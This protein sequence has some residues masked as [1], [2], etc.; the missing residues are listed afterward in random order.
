MNPAPQLSLACGA[1]PNTPHD[2]F[3]AGTIEAGFPLIGFEVTRDDWTSQTTRE[4]KSRLN[5]SPIEVLD[6]EVFF[7]NPGEENTR[8]LKALDI[9][10]ELGAKFAL[11]VSVDPDQSRNITRFAELCDAAAERDMVIALEFMKFMAVGSLES[12]VE[13]LS[14]VDHHASALLLD[15]LHFFRCGYGK[16]QLGAIDPTWLQYAQ[17]CDGLAEPECDDMDGLVQDA[18]F[19]RKQLGEGQLPVHDFLGGLPEGI[20]LSIEMRSSEVYDKYPSATERAKAIWAATQS[21]LEA[22]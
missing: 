11:T 7:L 12:S 6:I 5:D 20:P 9:G 22:S 8:L 16:K 15:T 14:E 1:M 2:E 3:L 21:Y 13:I 18:L 19:G 10:A 4:I 17:I